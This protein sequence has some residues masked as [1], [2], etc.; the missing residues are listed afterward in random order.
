[1]ISSLRSTFSTVD[2]QAYPR[3]IDSFP[4]PDAQGYA[5]LLHRPSHR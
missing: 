1:M 2:E 5:T 4:T 3:M